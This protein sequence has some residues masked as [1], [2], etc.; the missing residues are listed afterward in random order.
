[1]RKL[2]T[3]LVLSGMA[4]LL[5]L[6]AH[7]Q[8][9]VAE[10]VT[11]EPQQPAGTEPAAPAPEEAPAA[12][13]A[14]APEPAQ[15]SASA[16][17]SFDTN[18]GATAN[19]E[20]AA[21]QPAAPAAPASADTSRSYAGPASDAEDEWKFSYYGFFRAPMRLGIGKREN[22]QVSAANHGLADPTAEGLPVRP[23]KDQSGTTFHTPIVPD[24]QHLSWQKTNHS[25]KDWVELF[26]KYGN[27]WASG[28]ASLQAY[29]VT[30][31]GYNDVDTQLGVNQAF[32][33]ITP[34][35]P[36]ENVRFLLRGGSIANKY[37]MAGKYDAGEYDTYLFGR[38]A[39]MGESARVEVDLGDYTLGLEQGIGAKRADPSVYDTTRYT[40]LHHEH[41]DL[42]FAG[43]ITFT[44]GLH[45]LSSWTQS[46]N[47]EV[48]PAA[49]YVEGELNIT[50]EYPDG[51]MDVF[52]AEGRFE[53]GQFGYL[54][55][56]FSRV[57]AKHATTIA[58]AIEVVHSQG[59]GH[60]DIGIVGNY[61][62]SYAC[63][64]GLST[65]CSDGN[66][67][68]NTFLGQY[69]FT[70]ASLAE[71]S[72]FGEGRDLTTTLYGMYNTIESDDP[73]M[74]GVSRLK[75]GADLKFDLFPVLV[76]AL[77]ADHL[78]PHSDYASQ[79]FNII[80]P[81]VVFRSN[82]V[83]HEQISL[84]YSRY[85]YKKR[86]CEGTTPADIAGTYTDLYCVQPPPG[87]VTPDGFGAHTQNQDA[88]NRGAPTYVPDENVVTID[89]SIWW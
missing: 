17:V 63:R 55:A 53:L 41:A 70:V 64:F 78:E 75:F 89:A 58:P 86:T 22:K 50:D 8:Q 68:V 67:A 23:S 24:D 27:T 11:L 30:T 28:T 69:E 57:Q 60:Y 66:G 21:P 73:E 82:W 79:Q 83:T 12:E 84:Q 42:S 10:D 48:Q 65:K 13:E 56:G 51:K 39:V 88:G 43:P 40:M 46:E 85:F 20:A 74:D 61:L 62:D 29:N 1:M 47:P 33:T 77:R 2:R 87:A 32:V 3:S 36:W 18:V 49:G 34:Y 14:P 45:Y 35:M 71:A 16:G 6:A 54:Y 15:A 80:S 4:V 59:G 26:F 31:G 52:G 72:V 25:R 44:F 76:L 5:P 38:T 19:A 81:R 37:G 7:A 9:P